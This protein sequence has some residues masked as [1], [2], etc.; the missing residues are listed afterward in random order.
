MP[1]SYDVIAYPSKV[2]PQSHP[3]RMATHAMMFGVALAPI[4]ACRVLDI[5]GGDGANLITLAQG[6]PGA[7]FVSF[8]LADSAVRRGR[9]VIEALGL[10]NIDVRR[11]DIRD[12]DLGAEPFDYV[13]CHGVYS[14]IPAD[15]R[16]A[17]MA[18]IRRVLAPEGVAFV[19]YNA[20]PGCRMRQVLRDILLYQVRDLATP[21]D[22]AAAAWRY[23]DE[24]VD[25][26]PETGLFQ[27]LMKDEARVLK[28]RSLEVMAHD[29]LG[30]VYHPLYFHEFLSHCRQHGL[31]FLT[32]AESGRCAEGFPPPAALDDPH[33]DL[34]AHIQEM[35]FKVVRYFRQ[36]LLIHE[37]RAVERRPDPA[38]MF[39]LHVSTPARRNDKGV[40]ETSSN[41]FEVT[42]EKMAEAV[43]RICQAWP[44][45]VRV[46]DVIHDDE[47]A[48]VLQRMYWAGTVELH[49]APMRFVAQAGERPAAN[50]LARLQAA[51]GA[52]RLTSLRHALVDIEDPFSREFIAG[53][54][55]ARTRAELAR[56]VAARLGAPLDKAASLLEANLAVL[57]RMPM[58]VQ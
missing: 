36:S 40:F 28:E 41:S 57:A 7:R 24:I 16:E 5:G 8:D 58:L 56:D 29:E 21:E 1:T 35:D 26:Y 20:L 17:L 11:G 54:D 4:D 2:F 55:G 51:S 42:D 46:G 48:V 32:E 44:N 25:A 19:S 9:A 47:R 33:F 52:T 22:R 31:A 38:V 50:P 13:I 45:T 14:W 23:L 12:I 30:E 37:G 34:M 49:A 10:S 18:L 15:A 43:E 53:L 3:D 39:D 6:F 27:S